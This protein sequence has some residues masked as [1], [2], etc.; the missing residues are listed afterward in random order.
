MTD[1]RWIAGSARAAG[2]SRN[3]KLWVPASA[4]RGQP[5]PLVMMLHG[6]THGPEEMA[7]ISGMNDVADVNGFF[8]LYPEQSRLSNLLKCWNW[9]DPRHQARDGGEPA[10]LAAMVEQVQSAHDIDPNR[11]YLAGVSAGGAMA[12]VVAANYPDIFAAI[13]I[14]A[15]TEFKAASNVT[16]GLAVMKGGGPDPLRQGKLAFEAMSTGRGRTNRKRMP[17]IVFQGTA[18]T[19]VNPI[20]AE[21]AISQWSKTNECL[22]EDQGET[23]FLLTETFA[24][25]QAGGYGFKKQLYFERKHLLMEKWSIEGLGHAWCGSPTP[26]KYGDTKGPNASAEIWRF[27][28]EATSDPSTPD[29]PQNG[30]NEASR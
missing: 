20:N 3:F 6:C 4:D 5:R 15:G 30:S 17:A 23:P 19:R 2:G 7:Q 27:F 16:E 10:I 1:R 21:Q 26:S 25:G 22:A 8:V 29:Q 14:F 11:V 24:E 9:F 28:R 18:D 12:S 13:A